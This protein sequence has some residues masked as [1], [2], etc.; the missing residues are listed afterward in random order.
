MIGVECNTASG[1]YHVATSNVIVEVVDQTHDVDGV[2][3]GSALVTHLHSYATP[4][5]RYELGDLACL[6]DKCPCGVVDIGGRPGLASDETAAIVALLKERAG[7]EFEI[8]VGARN[9]IDW[10]RSRKRPGLRCEI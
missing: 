1:H 9:E 6:A 7:L 8:E 2:R 4:F 10:G 3:L 5:I